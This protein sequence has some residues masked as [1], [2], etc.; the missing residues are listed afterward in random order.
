MIVDR[1]VCLF[2]FIHVYMPTYSHPQPHPHNMTTT[3]NGRW[4]A[5]AEGVPGKS[6]KECIERYK[7]LRAA[8]QQQKKEKAKEGGGV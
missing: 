7:A 4:K 3:D 6:K 8:L 1:V 2:L 5:I